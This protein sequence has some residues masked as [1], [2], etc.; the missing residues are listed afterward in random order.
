MEKSLFNTFPDKWP[1]SEG[2]GVDGG[3]GGGVL[4]RYICR[5]VGDV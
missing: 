4:K 5:P 3:G 1:L 2:D